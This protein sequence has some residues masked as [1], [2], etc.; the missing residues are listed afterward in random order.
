[1]ERASE[2]DLADRLPLDELQ[3]VF[4]QE[5]VRLAVCFGSQ[6]SGQVHGHSDVDI[7]IELDGLQPGDEGYN[8]VYFRVYRKVTEGLDR[9]DVDLIDFHTLSGSLARA[10]FDTGVLLFGE[11]ERV[12][13]LRKRVDTEP[14][15]R[16]PRERLDRAIERMDEHLA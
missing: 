5:P 4:T 1:M 7:A 10:V 8:E 16:S 15:S 13:T 3:A 9:E 14:D 11:P 6:A 2:T 12:E